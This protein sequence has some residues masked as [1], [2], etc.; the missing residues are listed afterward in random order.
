VRTPGYSEQAPIREVRNPQGY[1]RGRTA[2]GDGRAGCQLRVMLLLAPWRPTPGKAWRGPALAAA[3]EGSIKQSEAGG[4]AMGVVSRASAG[5]RGACLGTAVY[6]R[7]VSLCGMASAWEVGARD[8]AARRT[9]RAEHP[10]SLT[11]VL[12]G[13]SA[14][15]FSSSASWERYSATADSSSASCAGQRG[16]FFS[17]SRCLRVN[18]AAVSVLRCF[19]GRYDRGRP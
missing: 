18:C 15:R 3:R 16:M 6:G 7:N 1:R 8:I 9:P 12:L 13:S 5:I 17:L 4:S 14:S 19:D 2:S 10:T 11:S